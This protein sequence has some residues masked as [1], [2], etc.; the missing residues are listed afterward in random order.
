MIDSIKNWIFNTE[1]SEQFKSISSSANQLSICDSNDISK[2]QLDLSSI[3]N[4]KPLPQ[5]CLI[6]SDVLNDLEVFIPYNNVSYE[7]TIFSQVNNAS[8]SGGNLFIGDLLKEPQYSQNILNKRIEAL[9]VFDEL[10]SKEDTSDLFL[11]LHKYENDVK[12]LYSEKDSTIHELL[13]IVYFRFYLLKFLNKSDVAL[14]SYNWYRIIVSPLIGVLSPIIYFVIPFL[15][16][17]WKFKHVF[18]ISFTTYMKLILKSFMNSNSIFNA[19][20]GNTT[21]KFGVLSKIQILSYIL[22]L[23]FY[24]QGFINSWDTSSNIYKICKFLCEKTQNIISYLQ[25]CLTLNLKYKDFIT[26]YANVFFQEDSIN[27]I[28]TIYEDSLM[29]SILNHKHANGFTMFSNFGEHLKILKNLDK[30]QL[31]QVINCSYF[32]D[33]IKGIIK[34]KH[35]LALQYPTLST[36][37]E[38]PMKCSNF[39]HINLDK[40][41]SVKNDMHISNMIITGPNAGGKSTLIKSLCINVYLSQTICIGSYDSFTF[42]PFYFINTQINIP[43]CKGQ[44]SLFEAEMNRCLYNLNTLKTLK[45]TETSL[46]VMDEIFNSTNVV[47][48]I[49]GAYSILEKLSSHKNVFTFITTHFV[50]LTK[51]KKSSDFKCYCMNVIKSDKNDIIY[52]YKVKKGISRQYIAL[53]LLK[54]RGFESSIVDRAI[55]IKYKLSF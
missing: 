3:Y 34:T 31:L 51:L 49:S 36:T 11:T 44:E 26:N 29:K 22:S 32:I 13:D 43:D 9:K 14:T 52:P 39:W 55:D 23:V 45:P 15:I 38:E 41:I 27:C 40:T 33:G 6:G 35:N 5:T 54:K 18:K 53:D 2:L 25:A 10:L 48:A 21:S 4:L 16:M 42:Y 12:W 30:Q 46:I 17:R 8:T 47:E 50:Y 28:N 1:L 37:L 20:E 19:L 24:F 7:D